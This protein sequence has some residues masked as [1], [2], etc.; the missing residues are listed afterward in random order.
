M[1]F[2]QR[3]TFLF[4]APMFDADDLEGLRVNQI[5]AAIERMGFQV[6]KARRLEDAARAPHDALLQRLNSHADGLSEHEVEAIRETA[7]EEAPWYVVPADNK[8]FT[9]VVVAAAV[10]M[11]SVFGGFTLQTDPIIKTIIK[12]LGAEPLE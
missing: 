6:I 10:I 12:E 1:N 2:F 3:F 7:S 8:W 4:S 11:I 5:I 9:R